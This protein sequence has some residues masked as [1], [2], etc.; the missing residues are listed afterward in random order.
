M[1]ALLRRGCPD[2]DLEAGIGYRRGRVETIV[3]LFPD[4]AQAV[5]HSE[6]ETVILANLDIAGCVHIN[7]SDVAG[8]GGL[9]MRV[10]PQCLDIRVRR[11]QETCDG[12]GV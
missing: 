2:S 11:R 5:K 10:E 3:Q 9:L 8:A 6:T 7:T 1:K 12:D 4:A